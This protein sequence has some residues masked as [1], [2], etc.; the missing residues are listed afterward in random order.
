MFDKTRRLIEPNY[1]SKSCKGIRVVEVCLTQKVSSCVSRSGRSK[2]S[3]PDI[4]IKMGM[5]G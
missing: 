5:I 1:N 2:V 3:F 4:W